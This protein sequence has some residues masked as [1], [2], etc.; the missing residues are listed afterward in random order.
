M[1]YRLFNKE[2]ETT[3]AMPAIRVKP[4][5]MGATPPRLRPTAAALR[6]MEPEGLPISESGKKY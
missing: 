5:R 2:P 1:D 3:L 6:I 4:E